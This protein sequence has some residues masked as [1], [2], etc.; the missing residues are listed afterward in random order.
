[1]KGNVPVQDQNLSI[2]H[3]C[4]KIICRNCKKSEL[5]FSLQLGIG[6]S[7]VEQ[8]SS[9][10]CHRFH[11]ELL[12]T[13]R[14]RKQSLSVSLEKCFYKVI[15]TL[16][17]LHSI[18][19]LSSAIFYIFH[20]SCY[21]VSL[22]NTLQNTS[23]PLLHYMCL[24]RSLLSWSISSDYPLQSKFNSLWGS[25]FLLNLLLR[26]LHQRR[27][28]AEWQWPEPRKKKKKDCLWENKK[29]L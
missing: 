20:F 12:I 5:D 23:S 16:V 21:T 24:A 22:R 25:G 13:P 10:I 1:M 15:Y 17:H 18:Y 6:K 9:H 27:D 4:P 29:P 3:V 8:G 14:C 11:P 2:L 28:S 7:S 26:W 19:L